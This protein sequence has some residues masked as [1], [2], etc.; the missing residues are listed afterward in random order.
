L[1]A[2][3]ALDARGCR[4]VCPLPPLYVTGYGGLLSESLIHVWASQAMLTIYETWKTNET[5]YDD[6]TFFQ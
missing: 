5:Y 6:T 2:H 4:P 1:D 3:L